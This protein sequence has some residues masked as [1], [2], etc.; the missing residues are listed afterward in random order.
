MIKIAVQKKIVSQACKRSVRTRSVSHESKKLR[1][2]VNEGR[3][4][5]LTIGGR[6]PPFLGGSRVLLSTHTLKTGGISGNKNGCSL[7]E[8]YWM[9]DGPF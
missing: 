9:P 6:L 7:W 8:M 1:V 4:S 2:N 5:S 3:V